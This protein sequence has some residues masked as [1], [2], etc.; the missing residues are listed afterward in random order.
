LDI[1][2]VEGI[3]LNIHAMLAALTHNPIWAI[4]EGEA[5]MLGE[6]SC[7]VLRHYNVPDVAPAVADHINFAI[8][9]CAI[10]GPRLAASKIN[11][12]KNENETTDNAP[13]ATVYPLMP[14]EIVSPSTH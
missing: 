6:S 5:H 14:H 8:A 4:N 2:A 9:L 13:T 10:Y 3:L 11:K 7:Q 12:N 1:K